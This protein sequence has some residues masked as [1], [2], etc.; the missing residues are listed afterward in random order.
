[1]QD[2]IGA[3][4]VKTLC[5]H[6]HSS[7]LR[8]RFISLWALKHLVLSASN[9]VKV[10]CL[11]ELGANWLI[12]TINGESRGALSPHRAHS[13][14]STPLGMGTP[15]AA[16][17]QVDLLN[18]I[19][20]PSMDIDDELDDE[21]EDDD[22]IMTDSIGALRGSRNGR[23]AARSHRARL[24]AIKEAEQN[25][26]LRAHRDDLQIQE[27]ALDYIRNLITGIGAFEMIDH[28][29]ST[30]G[31]ARFFDL[32]GAKLVVARPLPPAHLHPRSRPV[33]TTDTLLHNNNTNKPC[34]P[35]S[36]LPR[37]TSPT[38]TPAPPPTEILLATLFILVHI[39]AGTPRHRTLLINQT[40]L[41]KSLIPL[42]AHHDRRVRVACVWLV[43]NLTWVDDTADTS[44]AR[45]RAREL[46]YL[47]FDERLRDA[48]LDPDLDVRER[49]KTALE[50]TGRLLDGGVGGGGAVGGGAS[51]TGGA[52]GLPGSPSLLGGHAHGLGHAHG[53][54]H[55]HVHASRGS[56]GGSSGGGGTS[57]G[58][59]ITAGSGAGAGSR[60]ATG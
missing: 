23:H 41:L 27:Q 26:A 50:Q 17:E 34:P 57:I 39:A 18:A 30:L 2:L 52:A 9:D 14:S 22:D 13:Q 58:G 15:N 56:G 28:L 44:P 48:L 35:P 59:N 38:P 47:G 54:A 25:P 45:A 12:Q 53:H 33:S 11:D 19:D 21:S 40:P 42:F 16:G 6:A 20:E 24:R 32:L 60:F 7:N 36:T 4:A 5:E 37:T 29:L 8:I 51:G 46:R 10:S 43:N 1:M 49:A 3:G 55:S 31:T